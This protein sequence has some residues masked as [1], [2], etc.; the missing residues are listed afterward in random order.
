MGRRR[1]PNFGSRDIAA[2]ANQ[3]NIQQ[4][5]QD[6][7]MG[8]QIMTDVLTGRD[9]TAVPV[10]ANAL[11]SAR[12]LQARAESAVPTGAQRIANAGLNPYFL[13]N[14][15]RMR[16]QAAQEQGAAIFSQGVAQAMPV[17]LGAGGQ[18][19]N[20]ENEAVAL[21]ANILSNAAQVR[22]AEWAA[23]PPSIWGSIARFGLGALGTAFLGPI[24]GALGGAVANRIIRR[25]GP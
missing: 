4:A 11:A 22:Q 23:R 2:T 18:L 3:V 13:S 21:R 5:Q 16:L 20:R 15:E 1:P 6:A 25:P 9:F 19:M 10:F 12:A 7:Q 24:G 14:L 8:R 17:A